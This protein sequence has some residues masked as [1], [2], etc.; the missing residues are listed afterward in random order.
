MGFGP[1]HTFQLN[2]WNAIKTQSQ[3]HQIDPNRSIDHAMFSKPSSQKVQQQTSEGDFES[4]RPRHPSVWSACE[5]AQSDNLIS[6]KKLSTRHEQISPQTSSWTP[7][8][9]KFDMK[10]M[11]KW[12]NDTKCYFRLE[13]KQLTWL[14]LLT[15]AISS[16]S[17]TWTCWNSSCWILIYK[18]TPNEQTN[19]P[20]H[21]AHDTRVHLSSSWHSTFGLAM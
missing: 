5:N 18:W 19:G 4:L 20:R 13:N 6:L 14:T 1:A 8:K 7:K 15:L 9:F 16:T 12:P 21:S 3:K 10:K 11:Q 2:Y 17:R